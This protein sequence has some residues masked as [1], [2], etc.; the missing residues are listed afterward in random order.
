[1]KGLVPKSARLL[2]WRTSPQHIYEYE[3]SVCVDTFAMLLLEKI[4]FSNFSFK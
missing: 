4:R 3:L 2:T 1:M